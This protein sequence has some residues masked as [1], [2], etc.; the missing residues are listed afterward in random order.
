MTT[1]ET[2]FRENLA[3]NSPDLYLKKYAREDFALL[4]ENM[5][6]VE[7]LY[8]PE[9]HGEAFAQLK[10]R[11]LEMTLQAIKE[12]TV[13]SLVSGASDEQ[14]DERVS[15]L[16]YQ[17]FARFNLMNVLFLSQFDQYHPDAGQKKC[18]SH[19][20]P[21]PPSHKSESA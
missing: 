9:V 13:Q 11:Q 5:N 4:C 16:E 12:L 17:F 1:T 3:K 20:S 7:D 21:E 10:H 19:Q 15:E 2:N 14:V 18:N 6:R 8:Q